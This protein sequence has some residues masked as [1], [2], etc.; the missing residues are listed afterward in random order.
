VLA[1]LLPPMRTDRHLILQSKVVSPGEEWAPPRPGWVVARVSEGVGYWMYGG[2]A[3]E[4]KEGDGFVVS[5]KADMTI[6]ASQLGILKLEFYLLQPPLLNGLLTVTEENQLEQVA[7][8]LQVSVVF[9]N[10]T[11]ALGQKYSRLVHQSQPESLPAR[12]A[13][14]Q[15]WAQAVASLLTQPLVNKN[16]HKSEL[17][18]RFQQLVTQLPE[19][20]LAKLSLPQLAG[21]LECSERHFRRLFLREFGVSLRVRQAESR[22]RRASQLLLETNGKISSIAFESGY[23]HLGLFNIM[24]KKRFGCTPRAW[25]ERNLSSFPPESKNPLQDEIA[26]DNSNGNH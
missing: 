11:D 20:E 8:L 22:L 17:H 24:F 5:G 1:L 26:P 3:R 25:R 19:A 13:L 21:M 12:A 2:Q 23:H 16:G 9:F 14:V 10:A 18:R 6:R 15:F 4:L 7:N